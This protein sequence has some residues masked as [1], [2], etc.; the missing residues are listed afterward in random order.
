L[1]LAAGYSQAG[2]IEGLG[3]ACLISGYRS[4]DISRSNSSGVGIEN[5]ENP[6]ERNRE[7]RATRTGA[8]FRG[9]MG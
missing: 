4:F 3:F 1:P 7:T 9:I 5:R 8:F 2:N 6:K